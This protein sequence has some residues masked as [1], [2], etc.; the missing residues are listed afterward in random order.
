MDNSY[1]KMKWSPGER[2]KIVNEE[3]LKTSNAH[4][5]LCKSL[6]ILYFHIQSAALHEVA[7]GSIPGKAEISDKRFLPG[8]RRDGGA[9]PQSL[10][11]FQIYLG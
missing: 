1:Q 2:H 4:E 9:E 11:L 8:T 5:R 6:S 10:F 3:L 7:S